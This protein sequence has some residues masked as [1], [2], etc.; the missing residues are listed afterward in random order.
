MPVTVTAFA[1][2]SRW[3]L[4]SRSGTSRYRRSKQQ[5]GTGSQ[6][7]ATQELSAALVCDAREARPE[8]KGDGSRQPRAA[9]SPS[10]ARGFAAAP[11]SSAAVG[12]RERGGV[13]RIRVIPLCPAGWAGAEREPRRGAAAP[14]GRLSSPP[15][16]AGGLSVRPL[17]GPG[18]RG[19]ATLGP[20]GLLLNG[21]REGKKRGWVKTL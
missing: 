2:V 11:R 4:L 17:P 10:L 20:W 13:G 15:A 9:G 1:L 16:P 18:G 21:Q 6:G 5:W 7:L 3:R 12:W 19:R 14:C 8:G